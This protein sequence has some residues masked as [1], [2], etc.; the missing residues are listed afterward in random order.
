M[1]YK[2]RNIKSPLITKFCG[3]SKNFMLDLKSALESLGMPEK[4]LYCENNRQN[5]H[6]YFRYSHKNSLILFK[7]MYE[8]LR[9]DLYLKRK[10]DKFKAVIGYVKSA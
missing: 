3:G 2:R 8:G 7:I 9:N 5:P 6:Y 4:R 10:Y 1:Y